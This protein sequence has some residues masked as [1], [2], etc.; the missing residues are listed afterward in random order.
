MGIAKYAIKETM[1]TIE[2][3]EKK[4][5]NLFDLSNFILCQC[6]LVFILF[7]NLQGKGVFVR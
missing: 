3:I 7:F 1:I 6:F 4:T 5:T 2:V